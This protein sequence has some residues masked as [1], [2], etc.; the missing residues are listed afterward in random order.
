MPMRPK[1]EML[2]RLTSVLRATEE[3]RVGAG[4]STHGEF[5]ERQGLAT[6][7]LDA[8]TGGASEAEGSDREFGHFKEP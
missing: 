8:S 5:V 7:F 1:S 6:S 2:D 4:G 3:D